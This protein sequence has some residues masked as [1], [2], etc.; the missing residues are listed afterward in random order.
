MWQNTAPRGN[1]AG[2]ASAPAVKR[3]RKAVE[4]KA[5]AAASCCPDML[6]GT[7]LLCSAAHAPCCMH[8]WTTDCRADQ[9]QGCTKH[10]ACTHS[11]CRRVDLTGATACTRRRSGGRPAAGVLHCCSATPAANETTQF[12]FQHTQHSHQ[13]LLLLICGRTLHHAGR[14]SVGSPQTSGRGHAERVSRESRVRLVRLLLRQ[15]CWPL[16]AVSTWMTGWVVSTA[17]SSSSR[18]HKQG[19]RYHWLRA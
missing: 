6:M 10:R 9:M 19:L 7:H 11:R 12:N 3:Y 4:H 18:G 15:L 2:R 17:G 5:L 8:V 13:Q 14:G 16:H 1:P